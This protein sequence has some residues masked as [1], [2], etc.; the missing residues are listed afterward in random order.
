LGS[1]GKTLLPKLKDTGSVIIDLG[2]TYEK[3]IPEKSLYNFK[4]LLYFCEKLGII[5]QKIFTGIILQNYLCL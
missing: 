2:R 5:L 1:F 4:V 3:G